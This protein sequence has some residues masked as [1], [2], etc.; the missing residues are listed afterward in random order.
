MRGP[1]SIKSAAA[2]DAWLDDEAA[3]LA[4]ALVRAFGARTVWCWEDEPARLTTA[5]RARGLDARRFHPWAAA[6]GPTP[7]DLLI[8]LGRLDSLEE[9]Q[10]EPALTALAAAGAPV[11]ASFAPVGRR[12]PGAR[13]TQFWL[14][15]FARAD[16]APDPACDASF[17]EAG[18][19]LFRRAGPQAERDRALAAELVRLRRLAA[20]G[21]AERDRLQTRLAYRSD[22]DRTVV[23]GRVDSDMS[24]RLAEVEQAYHSAV[25]QLRRIE[26]SPFWRISAPVR[27]FLTD[28]PILRLMVVGPPK[29]VW[30]TLTGQ[31]SRRM[32]ARRE[33]FRARRLVRQATAMPARSAAALRKRSDL[34]IDRRADPVDIVVCVHNAPDDVRLCLSSILA[35]T[36]APYR[37]ILVDD[38]S[39][40]PTRDYLAAFAP[41]HAATLIRNEKARGYTFAANQGMRAS[42]APWVLLLNSDTIVTLGWLDRMKALAA[43]DDHIGVV[44]PMSNVASWQSTPT[45]EEGGDWAENPLPPDIDVARMGALVLAA[46]A[47]TGVPLPFINGFCLLIRKAMLDEIGLFD[48]EAFGAGYGEENDLCIRARNAGWKLTVAEDVFVFHAQSKSYSHERRLELAARAGEA[49]NAKHDPAIKIGPQVAHCQSSLA[50]AGVRARTTAAIERFRLVEEG[51]RRWDGRRIAIILPI[52]SIGGGGNV[53]LQEAAAFRR[54]GA[55]PWIVNLE[56]YAALFERSYPALDLPVLYAPD[57][58]GVADILRDPAYRFDAAIASV[59]Y[60]VYLLPEAAPGFRRAYYVQDYEPLF[61]E[62]DDP[63][64]RTAV[65][66]YRFADDIVMLAKTAWNADQVEAGGAARPAVNGPSVDIDLFRP[67]PAAFE[68]PPH[69][70]RVAAMVRPSTP[71][72]GPERT[73]ETLHALHRRFGHAVEISVFGLKP[74]EAQAEGLNLAGMIQVGE[75]DR[76]AM[77]R[78]LRHTDVFLD[79]SDYQAMGLTALEAMASGCAV[80]VP[81]RGGAT[82]FAEHEVNALVVDTADMDAVH[83]AAQRLVADAAL[84]RRL[85]LRAVADACRFPP[86]RAAFATLQALFGEGGR[87]A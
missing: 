59:Y 73:L 81:E 71:W 46:A 14:Q 52:A 75:L 60:S 49:L 74:G 3:G 58:A 44:G 29:L 20:A 34:E 42:H 61:F 50:M 25:E 39:D 8:C 13:P 31:L 1:A 62:V 54:L 56:A 12:S 17:A 35:C 5:L 43:R 21:E 24:R 57:K 83:D 68:E 45:V 9:A 22:Q 86:E 65:E 23:R 30:W 38:G 10:L 33:F 32:R 82:E 84:R 6:P 19:L 67:R 4:E 16:L 85:Q 87:D 28:A 76:E 53:I 48:E 51:R 79:L 11:L 77:A 41:A 36:Q 47:G 80:V 72:R 18:A 27:D 78:L 40:A 7:P 55:D 64:W 63:E 70:V 2:A 26:A 66:S 69:P 37:L 15:A